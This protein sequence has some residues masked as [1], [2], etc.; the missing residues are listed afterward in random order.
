VRQAS[1]TGIGIAKREAAIAKVRADRGRKDV[2]DVV[3]KEA[4]RKADADASVRA[5]A[6]WAKMFDK[7]PKIAIIGEGN[8]FCV[9][10]CCS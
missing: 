3:A 1:A 9:A 7:G 4:Q 8:I 2:T 6:E 10:D 5:E